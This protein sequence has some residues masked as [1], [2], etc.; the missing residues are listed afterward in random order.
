MTVYEASLFVSVFVSAFLFFLGYA[1]S[2]PLSEFQLLE[3][4]QFEFPSS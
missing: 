2:F 3:V 1:R 4:V